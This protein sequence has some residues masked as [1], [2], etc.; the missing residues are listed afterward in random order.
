MCWEGAGGAEAERLERVRK[1]GVE[2]GEG[3]VGVPCFR[4]SSEPSIHYLFTTEKGIPASELE[5]RHFSSPI[6]VTHLFPR[7]EK[8]GRISGVLEAFT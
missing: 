7:R 4:Q 5:K 8:K 3:G 2:A 1:G 6:K